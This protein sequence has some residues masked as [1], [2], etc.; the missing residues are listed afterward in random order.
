[1][2]AYASQGGDPSVIAALYVQK[3]GAYYNI[4][5]VDP[6]DEER[7]ARK[8]A[9]PHPVVA[10]PPCARW[11]RM[12][13]QVEQRHGLRVGEDGGCFD[14]ALASVRAYGGVLEHPAYSNAWPAF[15][16]PRPFHGDWF[17][18]EFFPRAW[19]TQVAQS[20]YGH[21][22]EKLTWLYYVGSKPPPLDWDRPPVARGNSWRLLSKKQRSATPPAFRDLLL[23]LARGATSASRYSK[24]LPRLDRAVRQLSLFSSTHNVVQGAN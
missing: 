11:C 15:G 21:R 3:N 7:D 2:I 18:D 16:L 22:Q 24:T 1:M 9:G 17:P 8:Y 20:A 12:A 5:D 4:P 6:W 14:S 23:D 19:T 10:H 13:V